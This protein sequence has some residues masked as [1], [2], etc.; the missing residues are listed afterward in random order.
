MGPSQPKPARLL[1]SFS[2]PVDATAF[3]GVPSVTALALLPKANV[4]LAAAMDKRVVGLDLAAGAAD[5][6]PAKAAPPKAP[7]AVRTGKHL[8]WSHDNWVHDLAVHPDG[9]RVATGGCDRRVKIWKWGEDQPQASFTAHDEWVRA[10]A[11]SPDGHLLASAGDDRLVRLWDVATARAVAT[12]DPHGSFLD[13]LAWTVDGKQ[14][15]AGGNDGKISFWDVEQQKLLRTID[16]ENRRLIEDEPLNGGFS[17]PGGIRG[18]TCSPD[19]K[20]IA[21]VGLTSL[22]VLETASGKQI[23][24]LDGRGFGVAFDPSSRWLAFSQEKDLL[25]WDFHTGAVCCRIPVD[26]LGIFGICFLDGGR[27][28]AA[29]GC[30]GRVGV[31]ELPAA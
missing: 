27:K 24:K 4:L 23:H 9:E 18:L 20:R 28:L 6:T 12:L 19:G 29:G 1:E 25:V 31:W 16:V 5:P 15:L 10:V 30:N 21:V 11:F 17:Y 14:L 3:A 7:S 26:Q 2:M 22:H 8:A 13:T